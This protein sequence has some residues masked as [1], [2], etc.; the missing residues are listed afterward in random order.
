MKNKQ[1]AKEL[2]ELSVHVQITLARGT[3]TAVTSFGAQCNGR[4]PEGIIAKSLPEALRAANLNAAATL[5]LA[6]QVALQDR[7]A[8]DSNDVNNDMFRTLTA[9]LDTTD[10][11]D[12]D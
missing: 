5:A 3:H 7:G 4:L 11:D 1:L 8:E 6:L 9:W 2:A 10:M 12:V